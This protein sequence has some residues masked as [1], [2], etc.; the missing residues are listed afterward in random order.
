MIAK[1]IA[2]DIPA[3]TASRENPASEIVTEEL[4]SSGELFSIST[5]SQ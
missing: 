4:I 5:R 2:A 1:R 3:P